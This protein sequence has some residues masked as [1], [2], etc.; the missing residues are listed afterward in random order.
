M[1]NNNSLIN[2]YIS[3]SLFR[4]EIL[5][6][7]CLHLHCLNIYSM[8]NLKISAVLNKVLRFLRLV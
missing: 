4:V 2:A 7:F 3:D 8:D 5:K 1:L 6:L